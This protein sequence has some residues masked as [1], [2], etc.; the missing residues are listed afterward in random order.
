LR[1][2]ERI[3][4]RRGRSHDA[5]NAGKLA[6]EMRRAIERSIERIP[7]S[8]SQG[9]IPASPYR[10]MDAG[11]IGSLVADYPLQLYR[12]AEPRIMA[13]VETLIRD[14]FHKGGFFQDIIHSGINAYLT[15][16][17]AQTLLRAGD[18]RYRDLMET[19]A[20]LATATGQWPEA[21]HPQ[22][23]G[24]C[25][26]DGQHGWAAAE[27]AMM[28]RSLFVREEGERLIVGSGLFA[29]WFDNT[30]TGLSEAGYNDE[31]VFG[32]TLTPWGAVTIRIVQ[33]RSAPMLTIDG[34]WHDGAT[35]VD[36]A[37]PGFEQ[38]SNVDA[39]SA[40]RLERTADAS[41]RGGAVQQPPEGARR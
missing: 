15:L 10:R 39:A 22:T 17:I 33:P 31:I 25:M 12:P 36:V 26:G 13:T 5:A 2:A 8:R 14:Y 28:I 29:E 6:D 35:R 19:V 34:Q 23:L 18:A 41:L 24:G 11:A 38:L 37:I 32:P 3:F 40:I 1:A 21:I 20:R 7:A 4:T 27:W 16:D 30:G 9:G